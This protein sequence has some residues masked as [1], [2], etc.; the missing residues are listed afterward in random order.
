MERT[1]ESPDINIDSCKDI[2][3]L[4]EVTEAGGCHGSITSWVVLRT[5]VCVCI[6]IHIYIYSVYMCMVVNICVL[7]CVSIYL[8]IIIPINYYTTL[9]I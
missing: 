7:M 8:C 5:S 2:G 3:R 6:Y 9:E 1:K 4:Q